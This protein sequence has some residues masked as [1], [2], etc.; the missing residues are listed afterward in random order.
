VSCQARVSAWALLPRRIIGGADSRHGSI[1]LRA[2]AGSSGPPCHSFFDQVLISIDDAYRIRAS[3]NICG[4]CVGRSLPYADA[5]FYARHECERRDGR[6][7]SSESSAAVSNGATTFTS[8]VEPI[9]TPASTTITYKTSTASV[10]SEPTPTTLNFCLKAV[11]ADAP[12]YGRV[13]HIVRLNSHLAMTL[14]SSVVYAPTTGHFNPETST[15][16]ALT[17]SNTA[18][19]GFQVLM[20][21]T[22]E[23]Q[24]AHVMNQH[25]PSSQCTLLFKSRGTVRAHV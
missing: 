5:S 1:Q 22:V 12:S 3:Y 17:P 4:R 16:G 25:D 7:T 6:S 8:T 21:S 18:W 11:T 15:T 20:Q 2:V 23:N 13:V 24:V 10:I 14:P 19:P 9:E